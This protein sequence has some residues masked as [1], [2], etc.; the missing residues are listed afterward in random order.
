[1][2]RAEKP[3]GK[4]LHRV[5]IAD[6]N[7]TPVKLINEAAR[8][9]GAPSDFKLAIFLEMDAGHLSRIR[10]RIEPVSDRFMVDIAD[11]TG[12]SIDHIRKLAG[13]AFDGERT[14]VIITQSMAHGKRFPRRLLRD[15]AD[16]P[17]AAAA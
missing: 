4:R 2:P 3:R 1:M 8:E 6:P 13:I 7:Y 10:N 17:I 15:P 9:L 12:W 5:D 11:R 14:L 16:E